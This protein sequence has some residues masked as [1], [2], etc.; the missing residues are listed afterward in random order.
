[1][2]KNNACLDNIIIKTVIS[3]IGLFSFEALDYWE[4]KSMMMA[5]TSL[6]TMA[7][8]MSWWWSDRFFHVYTN[9]KK[10]RIRKTKY[11]DWQNWIQIQNSWCLKS[12]IGK[13]AVFE[14]LLYRVYQFKCNPKKITYCG[15]KMKSEVGPPPPCSRL[16]QPA[17]WHSSQGYSGCYAAAHVSCAGASI[18]YSRAERVFILE[19]YFGWKSFAAVREA[20]SNAYPDK[21]V[22]NKITIYQL[23]TTFRDRE[24]VCDMKH[25]RRPTVFDSWEGLLV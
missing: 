17:P 10:R 7:V 8:R 12:M 25:F 24:S 19:H 1:M 9:Y 2:F 4:V 11:R 15:T 22:P 20:F 14:G 21:E 18:V 13:T 3:F 6:M 23:V 16:S 5:T